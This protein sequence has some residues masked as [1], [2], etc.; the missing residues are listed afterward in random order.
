M[1]NHQLKLNSAIIT[2][3]RRYKLRFNAKISG[4]D[5]MQ[6]CPNVLVP[7]SAASRAN[8]HASSLSIA[9]L[10]KIRGQVLG[11]HYHDTEYRR[12]YFR[13]VLKKMLLE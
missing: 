1:Y 10:Q 13:G 9:D 2:H 4:S 7:G 11:T 8:Q 3:I 5:T 12:N 6:N